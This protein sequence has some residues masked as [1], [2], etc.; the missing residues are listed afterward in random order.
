MA[1]ILLKNNNK[2]T[3]EKEVQHSDMIGLFD[4]GRTEWKSEASGTER[5][6]QLSPDELAKVALVAVAHQ[7]W[8]LEEI[9]CGLTLS[10]GDQL[11][12][13]K[14]QPKDVHK[15]YSFT[16][17]VTGETSIGDLLAQ[18]QNTDTIL[19]TSY[20]ADPP[21][22]RARRGQK[23]VKI[24]LVVDADGKAMGSQLIY[25]RSEIT[26]TQAQI[27][28][29][30]AAH[31]IAVMRGGSPKRLKDIPIL[32]TQGRTQI[33]KWNSVPPTCS[34]QCLPELLA[35]CFQSYRGQT[36]IQAWDG[37]FSYS[38][39]DNLSS[40]LAVA[41]RNNLLV[42]PNIILPIY[43]QRSIWDIVNL[44][45]VVRAGGGFLLID[46]SLPPVRLRHMVSSIKAKAVL[47]SSENADLSTEFPGKV[48]VVDR[49]NITTIIDMPEEPS[50]MLV[51]DTPAVK[52]SDILYTVFTSGTTGTPKGI[53]V[54][55]SSF[56]TA[57]LAHSKRFA[58]STSSRVLHFAA[59]TFDVSISEIFMTLLS[60][61]CLCVPSEFQRMNA[62]APM[63]QDMGVSCAVLTPSVARLLE[64]R[65]LPRL[66]TLILTGE[67]YTT[68]DVERW[69]DF[70]Q[71]VCAY[72]PA[73]CSVF[74]TVQS[75]VISAGN[76][77]YGCGCRCWIVDKENFNRL[78]PI[79][80]I[81]ELLI[82]GPI[83]ARGYLSQSKADTSNAFLNAED[84]PSWCSWFP[85]TTCNRFYRTGDLVRYEDDGSILYLGRN[86]SQIK[87]HGQRV[88][89][90]E[91]EGQLL[92]CFQG[93]T[94]TI[95]D[96][97]IRPQNH[98]EQQSALV[99]FL[100][101]EEEGMPKAG[102]RNIPKH[103]DDLFVK[104]DVSFDDRVI[105]AVVELR[106]RLPRFMVP[107]TFIRL[108]HVPLSRSGKIDRQA[109][110]HAASALPH[111]AFS[112]GYE[113]TS[114]PEAEERELQDSFR[115]ERQALRK[116]I[117]RILHLHPSEVDLKKSIF[118][119]GADSLAVMK[120]IS[121][122]REEGFQLTFDNVIRATR[123]VDLACMMPKCLESVDPK[124]VPPFSMA[125]AAIEL[126]HIIVQAAQA[127]K[128]PPTQI[129][130]IYPTS[131]FQTSMLV[132]MVG[133]P[134]SYIDQYVYKL[135]ATTDLNRL[136]QA[137]SA[138]W[139]AQS[140]LRTR[141]VQI[142][143]KSLQVVLR[144][145]SLLPPLVDTAS[146][147]AYLCELLQCPMNPGGPLAR[148]HLARTPDNGSRL[149]LTL[150]HSVYDW[151]SLRIL[152]EEIEAAYRT[153]EPRPTRL[154]SSFVHYLL[155]QNQEAYESFWRAEFEHLELVP[156]PEARTPHRVP[157][158]QH[159]L[160]TSVRI[161][162]LPEPFAGL[163]VTTLI[164]FAW[165]LT[166]AQY[167]SCTDVV[168]GLVVAGRGAPVSGILE[169]IGPTIHI[170]PLR[171]KICP[172]QT[173]LEALQGLQM[174]AST[175]FQFEHYG[176]RR[177]RGLG[178]H[179]STASRFQNL[180]VIQ[181][182][183]ERDPDKL[184]LLGDRWQNPSMEE[185]R[186][187]HP[188]TLI[189]ESRGDQ[190]GIRAIF[191]A[192]IIDEPMV[193][194]VLQQLKHVLWQVIQRPTGL[195]SR[196]E[197]LN[198]HDAIDLSNW[199][200]ILPKKSQTCIH[201]L[202]CQQGLAQPRSPAVCAWDGSM[203]YSHL[204]ALAARL[205]H[206]LIQRWA[207][208]PEE[209][210]AIYMAKSKWVP[211]SM[212]AVLQAGGAFILL[213]TSQPMQKLRSICQDA[214]VR[215]V[216]SCRLNREQASQLVENCILVDSFPACHDQDCIEL[217][218]TEGWM[219]R[220]PISSNVA[221]IVF[222][223]G[224]TG[225]AK[226]I[227]IEHAAFCTS[228]LAH[229]PKLGVGVNSRVFQFASYAFDVSIADH[230]ATLMLGGCVCIPSE[231]ERLGDFAGAVARYTAN[232]ADLT[233]S[234]A[235]LLQPSSV[236][237]LKTLTL[238]GEAVTAEDIQRWKDHVM[239]NCVYG[240]A[241]CS[242]TC[243]VK[244]IRSV[245]DAGNIG[246][247][248]GC[249]IWLVAPDDPCMLVPIGAIG[250]ILI[251]GHILARGYLNNQTQTGASFLSHLPWL[252]Q[253]GGPSYGPI[254]RSGD[255]ARYN[256]DGSL[257]FIA[258][259]D[260][261]VKIHGQRVELSEVAYHVR[262]CFHSAE[263]AVA[264][265]LPSGSGRLHPLLVAFIRPNL[266]SVPAAYSDQNT[267][268]ILPPTESFLAEV[269]AALERLMAFLPSYMIPA[270]FF[271]INR[272]P[273][274][275]TGKINLKLLQ[276]AVSRLSDSQL[277]RYQ[278]STT[279]ADSVPLQSDES[280]ALR[281]N[282]Q[283]QELLRGRS[284]TLV[285]RVKGMNV[286]LA[287]VGLT[288]I[289]LVVLSTFLRHDFGL[290][291]SLQQLLH[292]GTTVRTIASKILSGGMQKTEIFHFRDLLAEI[293]R[294]RPQLYGPPSR[295]AEAPARRINRVF[296][297]GG[298]G[299]LG[300]EILHQLLMR[301]Q[302]VVVHVLVRAKDEAHAMQRIVQAAQ[303]A[304]WW[305]EIYRVRIEAWVGDLAMQHLGLTESQWEV[306]QTSVDVIIHNGAAVYWTADY[307]AL[308]PV[309]ILSTLQLLNTVRAAS[310][311]PPAFIYVSGGEGHSGWE[312]D[313]DEATA[314]QLAKGLA[315]SQTKFV[316]ELLIRDVARQ[317]D[318]HGHFSIIRPGYIIGSTYAGICNTDDFIWRVVYT[319]LQI[320]GFNG[321]EQ[322]CWIP[323]AGVDQVAFAVLAPCLTEGKQ[324]EQSGQPKV[325]NLDDGVL[326]SNFWDTVS[327]TLEISL[328]PMGRQ[329]WLDAVHTALERDGPMHPL[330]PVLHELES[331]GGCLGGKRPPGWEA[332]RVGREQLVVAL[333]QS[334]HF[335]KRTG[336]F[337]LSG[338]TKMTLSTE[339]GFTRSRV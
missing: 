202:I 270:F 1:N 233:P 62:L 225:K 97:V 195:I 34:S 160:K 324:T 239:L 3:V 127:C 198:P 274:S 247:A 204:C 136:Q 42:R 281:I 251:E 24:G 84:A 253:L 221:Y 80:A 114:L 2:S 35:T 189:C 289:E 147:K 88:D 321:D 184:L 203:T 174:R 329:R 45:G 56:V 70:V 83:V 141:L 19:Q 12:G 223:S 120:L 302:A 61:G 190:I 98:N 326:V 77:G 306:I 328:V 171:V 268:I 151:W 144:E 219:P 152:E 303:R 91:I 269:V 208:Q 185:Q 17:R 150:H 273:L 242:V 129:E 290:S 103:T 186:N 245:E 165:A 134:G 8:N 86:D 11:N 196:L 229:G 76:I 132:E 305:Q 145:D 53:V 331:N 10:W 49:G 316:S 48:V 325:A 192:D 105:S 244:H 25:S 167:T 287:R 301:T 231:A 320:G 118:G 317:P 112:P 28:G 154:F 133:R 54:E 30:T 298:S 123:I 111:S 240:P 315:Y 43:M 46:A 194:R 20:W 55:Q 143:L 288:S 207:I 102:K 14:F 224:T 138:V 57:V 214:S 187:S 178:H 293:D 32:C 161:G 179:A 314:S 44:L 64:P 254:Y 248:V 319:S 311:P 213:D 59:Y 63:M 170:F 279:G 92:Q 241:E 40:T 58:L 257:T 237:G 336:Y 235:R 72:G 278:P 249:R 283:I 159:V 38:Q 318:S 327:Q 89:L 155:N 252:E 6:R 236:P 246:A 282:Q 323:L 216:L 156:F 52:G 209:P 122:V 175:L 29:S 142:G 238:G 74:S 169:I 78:L 173:A 205:A 307:A 9:K 304:K 332:P 201:T 291:L 337:T 322:D 108:S 113:T 13:S 68:Y 243:T 166:L 117:G 81:G 261:Q 300:I 277:H 230:L 65:S 148:V 16:I 22:D 67:A 222:T 260:T 200:K 18:L 266:Q 333:Q 177:I 126:K 116:H 296:L 36:S 149:I 191:D 212:L 75:G 66:E 128:V 193:Q 87:I 234:F 310:A 121:Y 163:T 164:R 272:L 312:V 96:M 109:L 153:M 297:T 26:S 180:L 95:V 93:L 258:R 228:V 60:G 37:E 218:A 21:C 313:G 335:L 227:L 259:K 157:S 41:L 79:G 334:L 39:L 339:S 183:E 217:S 104:R 275:P 271:P 168:Y 82:E 50:S 131:P 338:S 220:L 199:N 250:E 31:I 33:A 292:S 181:P 284:A 280:I 137:V 146:L 172:N 299:F 51:C 94:A 69:R 7:W 23:D 115:V 47:T 119:L 110:R 135:P 176:L 27:I 85:S 206:Q 263:D 125:P 158:P 100:Y 197:S 130:D 107:F 215:I 71:L 295:K 285:Q 210:V 255:L 262:S 294:L 140:I 267:D 276:A 73:E 232:Y 330:Q 106:R 226:G 5:R 90:R 162:T 309:N 308:E 286:H 256:N 139:K 4:I 188:L 211:V 101:L 182:T 15:S 99:A 265:V 264:D 124:I